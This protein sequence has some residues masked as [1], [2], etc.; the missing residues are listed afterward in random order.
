MA[1]HRAWLIEVGQDLRAG[2]CRQ[3]LRRD[4]GGIM[5]TDLLSL[6]CSASFIQFKPI[7]PKTAL[8]VVDGTL[9]HQLTIQKIP[10][11]CSQADLL[12]A[13]FQVRLPLPRGQHKSS[14][15]NSPTH[16]VTLQ[17]VLCASSSLFGRCSR[18]FSVL[19][20]TRSKL[21]R[22]EFIMFSRPSVWISN[23]NENFVVFF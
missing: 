3:E 1:R 23:A 14:W 19:V 15:Q 5:L 22:S 7:C 10:Q 18:I 12:E 4:L 17:S 11:P 20:L 13:I 2:I 8:P 16:P 9:L 6:A 21:Q